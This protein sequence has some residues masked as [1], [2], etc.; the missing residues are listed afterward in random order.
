MCWSGRCAER[1]GMAARFPR[2]ARLGQ[3]R[4]REGGRRRR[5]R[6]G[7]RTVGDGEPGRWPTRVGGV[8]GGGSARLEVRLAAWA[9]VRW[10]ALVAS[11]VGRTMRVASGDSSP[12]RRG[13][14]SS[15]RFRI[16]IGGNSFSYLFQRGG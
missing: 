1:S 5:A 11:T 2:A 6:R 4:G 14:W 3:T 10:E 9:L 7:A 15:G 12:G 16:E 13:K 8:A